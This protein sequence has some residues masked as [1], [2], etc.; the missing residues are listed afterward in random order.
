[1]LQTASK[2]D[3]LHQS[4]CNWQT[5]HA[6]CYRFETRLVKVMQLWCCT[7]VEHQPGVVVGLSLRLD[8]QKLT[9]TAVQ[10][11]HNCGTEKAA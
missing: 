11:Y 5:C 3:A 4:Y 6:A 2:V 9:Y 1:M 8:V 10:Q 7:A